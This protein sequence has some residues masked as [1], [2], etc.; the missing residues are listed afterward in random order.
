MARIEPERPD[1]TSFGTPFSQRPGMMERDVV[2]VTRETLWQLEQAA[3]GMRATATAAHKAS[4][5]SLRLRGELA[6]TKAQRQRED[7]RH[8]AAI[9]ALGLFGMGIAVTMAATV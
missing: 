8:V 1:R 6:L 4:L 7:G 3:S 5:A 2:E 9:F